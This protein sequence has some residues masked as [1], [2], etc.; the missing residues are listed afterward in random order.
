MLAL[1]RPIHSCLSASDDACERRVKI[2]NIQDVIINCKNKPF[3]N[4]NDDDD[5]D[6]DDE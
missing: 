5:D 1:I 4:N 3:N 2:L 6:D